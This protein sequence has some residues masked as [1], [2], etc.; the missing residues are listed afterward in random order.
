MPEQTFTGTT[1]QDGKAAF[2]LPIGTGEVAVSHPQY[3][4]APPQ[5]IAIAEG[6]TTEAFFRLDARAGGLAVSVVDSAGASVAGAAVVVT[7]RS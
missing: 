3:R 6:Q 1:D 2:D 4:P 7:L 5:P